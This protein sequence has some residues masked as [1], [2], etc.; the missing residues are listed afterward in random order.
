M[1]STLINE[2]YSIDFRMP[3]Y[4][5]KDI[6]LLED[7][8]EQ[9]SSIVDCLQDNLYGTLNIALINDMSI[10]KDQAAIIRKRYWL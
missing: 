6:K 2:K 3:D 8:I 10:T 1:K 7:G 5:M 9:N 4:L